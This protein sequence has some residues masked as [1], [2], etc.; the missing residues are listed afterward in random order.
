MLIISACFKAIGMSSGS[1]G[2]QATCVKKM[3]KEKAGVV[4]STCFIG[5]DIGNVMS[6][7]IGSF[8]V[9]RFGYRNMYWGYGILALVLGSLIYFLISLSEKKSENT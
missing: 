7:I 9:E 4:S 1:Q 5:Q 2:I 8:A 6:P 3:G